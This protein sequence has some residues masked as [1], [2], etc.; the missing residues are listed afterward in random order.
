MEGGLVNIGRLMNER[1][2]IAE[3]MDAESQEEHECYGALFSER[4]WRDVI[5][6]EIEVYPVGLLIINRITIEPEYR[7]NGLGV[8]LLE[9]LLA[10][11]FIPSGTIVTLKP[12]AL[13]HDDDQSAFD[14]GTAKLAAYWSKAGLRPVPDNG[15][16]YYYT[17]IE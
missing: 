10:S 7:R 16:G 1:V 11:T 17:Y 9:R 15:F 12:H 3:V 4:A 2:D 14:V 5:L 8:R 13:G 6:D